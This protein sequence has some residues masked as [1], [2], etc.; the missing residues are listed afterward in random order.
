MTTIRQT[1]KEAATDWAFAI[2]TATPPTESRTHIA[3]RWEAA[4]DYLVPIGYQDE[5]G[6]RYG[7]AAA[8]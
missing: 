5:T 3:V 1:D 6:F 8:A 2:S 4:I 7:E